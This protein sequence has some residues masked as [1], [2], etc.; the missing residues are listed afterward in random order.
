MEH[1]TIRGTRGRQSAR[2]HSPVVARHE[3]SSGPLRGRKNCCT[4]SRVTYVS[5]VLHGPDGT[6]FTPRWSLED[7]APLI[8]AI[9]WQECTPFLGAGASAG[10][11]PLGSQIARQWATTYGYPFADTDNLPRVAKYVGVTKRDH[12]LPVKLLV[13][14]FAA[15]CPEGYLDPPFCHRESARLNLPLY[16]TSNYDDFMFEALRQTPR[17]QGQKTRTP[18]MMIC[19]WNPY[20]QQ[21][22]RPPSGHANEVTGAYFPSVEHPLVFHLHGHIMMRQSLVVS[23]DDYLEF[24]VN[25]SRDDCFLPPT[26]KQAISSNRLLFLG[27]RLE[28]LNFKVLLRRLAQ[29]VNLNGS[30]THV[31]VQLPPRRNVDGPISL[32]EDQEWEEIVATYFEQHFSLEGVRVYFGSCEEFFVE[33]KWAQGQLDSP[34][35]TS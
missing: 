24:L 14:L 35:G 5:V 3:S 4:L 17:K 7:W 25:I 32:A 1:A 29:Y 22:Y 30:D 9:R 31:A 15:E 19:P 23:E 11:L 2:L 27:Y 16:M 13:E 28:D 8:R 34:V 26:V 18:A 12:T 6:A 21:P 20:L 33:L 10:H